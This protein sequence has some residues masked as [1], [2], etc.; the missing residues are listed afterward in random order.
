MDPAKINNLSDLQALL[1]L[2]DR[3][4]LLELEIQSEG[5]KIRLRKPEPQPRVQAVPFI[6]GAASLAAVPV[7]VPGD[8]E[9]RPAAPPSDLHQV[10]SPM[11]G[12]FFR[13]ASP[14]ADPFVHEG[15]RVEENATLCIIEAMKVMNEI[16]SDVSG[17][18]KEILIKNGESVEFGQPL[19]RIAVE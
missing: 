6:P 16:P 1:D 4:G 17:V 19:F 5:R 13:A 15:D 3:Y 18:I 11:V 12:T 2:M 9:E 8:S 10:P 7:E 14:E